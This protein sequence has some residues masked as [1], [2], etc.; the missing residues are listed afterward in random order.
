MASSEGPPCLTV[1]DSAALPP[2][3]A[4]LL[5]R[6]RGHSEEGDA[7][8]LFRY[9]E[10]H[11][12][13]LR[14]KYLAWVRDLGESMTGGRRL[15]ERFAVDR[16]LSAWWLTL[17]VEQSPWNSPAIID[18]LRLLALE[19]IVTDQSP[20]RV[21]LVSANRR[22]HE[23]LEAFSRESGLGYEWEQL[24]APAAPAGLREWYR[25][26]MPQPV[27]ALAGLARQLRGRWPLRRTDRS[28]WTSGPRSV[29]LCS[30][31]FHV[32]PAAA[33]AGEFRS[34][35]WG[36][37]HD[38]MRELKLEPNWLQLYY[39]QGALANPAV[40]AR[41]V[42][43]FNERRES[44]GFHAFLDSYLSWRVVGRAVLRWAR[45]A[46]A[47][48]RVP[49]LR[50]AF[51]PAGSRLSF[52]PLMQDDWCNSSR[53]PF[54]MSSALAIEQFDDALGRLP[55]QHTGIYLFEGQPWERAMLHAWRKHG[56]GRI[57][58]VAHS[59]VRFW[60][61]RYF[62]DVRTLAATG[63]HRQPQ[64]D[65]IALTGK[66]AVDAY[67]AAGFPGERM[68]E[69]E[70]LRYGYLNDLP[71][72]AGPAPAPG[73]ALR[74]LI[75]GDYLPPGTISMLRLLEA[76]RPL[77]GRPISCTFKPHPN[78]MVDIADYPSLELRIVEQPL[79]EIMDQFDAAYSSN[80]TSACVDA[81]LAG[82]PVVI[83]LDETAPN[84]SPLRGHAGV[85]FVATP[86]ELADA[87]AA[88]GGP[89]TARPP[90]D[91]L[92]LEPG[93]SHWRRLLSPG[94]HAPQ[95]PS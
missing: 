33:A 71:P 70:A 48:W 8:S 76:A 86:R 80:M 34:G 57:I 74:L 37:L 68:V 44:Q 58:G 36:G 94:D 62:S 45:V 89:A 20:A 35:Y 41:W 4:G 60:D 95:E 7:R 81:H 26:H 18:A 92:F 13:R 54:A 66:A 29:L 25:Q 61:L 64:P 31:F 82:L 78:F 51:R 14:A 77:A 73:A 59:T 79:G 63:P 32:A 1:W 88:A 75:L 42:A 28:G 16:G 12:D 15:I 65:Q 5:Y 2:P 11:G 23:V 40:A 24:P 19:E 53:G 91:L 50:S 90:Q 38:L 93:L 87:L 17:F 49:G 52:W 47:T 10:A 56:H 55:R 84:F 85:R 6:W 3:T 21:R 43:G 9:V 46:A 27:Q 83:T 67:L 72:V 69:A 22:L 30:Y 39:P